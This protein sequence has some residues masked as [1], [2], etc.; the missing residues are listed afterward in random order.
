MDHVRKDI[1]TKI[2]EALDAKGIAGE[3][4][5]EPTHGGRM[6]WHIEGKVMSPGEAADLYLPGGFSA[7]FGTGI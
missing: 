6:R 3:F 1:N 5:F 2:Q 7:N 4:K